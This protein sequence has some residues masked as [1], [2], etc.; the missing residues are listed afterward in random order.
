[1]DREVNYPPDDLKKFSTH[2]FSVYT[3]KLRMAT[4][5]AFPNSKTKPRR[6]LRFINLLHPLFSRQ[7]DSHATAE[8]CPAAEN[9][10]A[11]QS[12]TQLLR[13]GMKSQKL[14]YMHTPYQSLCQ[15]QIDI[16]YGRSVSM[17]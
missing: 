14:T 4:A 1:V 6:G 16:A 3:S 8:C 5:F 11:L 15:Y 2:S 9:V 13:R 7:G 10:K 17:L 12:T